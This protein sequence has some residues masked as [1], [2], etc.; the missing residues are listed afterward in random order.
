MS[1]RIA[2]QG[3][4]VG[5]DGSP[6]SLAAVRWA[7]R[8]ARLRDVPLHVVHVATGDE[9][10]ADL[11]TEA[12]EVARS[13]EPV[14]VD[15][16]VIDGDPV[17]ALADLSRDAQTVVVGC[18]GK[19]ARLHRQ[20]GSV[21]TGLLRRASCPVAVVHTDSA[22]SDRSR[23]RPVLVGIDGSPASET[24]A[25]I[26]FDEASWRGVDLLALH[27]CSDADN[28]FLNSR[29]SVQQ[30]RAEEILEGSLAGAQKRHPGVAVHRLIRSEYPAR[31]LVVHAERSQ[32]VVVGGRGRGG[33]AGMPLGS[34][35]T[36]A[37]RDVR[38]PVIVAR[39]G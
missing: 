6:S 3:L 26:A 15:G 11:L 25:E 18:H 16:A 12:I 5:V 9:E 24:A 35:S 27:V 33:S 8:E 29:P 39:C 31:Q 13:G 21:S 4:I 23:N 32:L 1:E 10:A 19:A 30:A 34:V 17:T 7:T 37:A 36:A 38:A 28:P 22:T 14:E 20:L 2:P